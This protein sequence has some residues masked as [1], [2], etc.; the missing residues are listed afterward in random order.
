MTALGSNSGTSDNDIL[1]SRNRIALQDAVD[2][3][4]LRKEQAVRTM[5]AAMFRGYLDLEGLFGLEAILR[6]NLSQARTALG[7]VQSNVQLG[8]VT[9]LDVEA[10]RLVILRIE[11]DIELVLNNIWILAF[12]LENPSLLR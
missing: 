11:Q 9:H 12:M 7:V 10:A 8:Y 6:L 1:T 3:A 4:V 2:L 5:E